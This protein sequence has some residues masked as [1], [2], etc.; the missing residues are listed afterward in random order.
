MAFAGDIILCHLHRLA[1]PMQKIG[2]PSGKS[3]LDLRG[4]S[5]ENT[6][7]APFCVILAL[8]FAAHT[9]TDSERLTGCLKARG[10]EGNLKCRLRSH[11]E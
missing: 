1:V 11:S 6:T 7:V 9:L 10:E 8:N 2:S 4:S 3:D 5:E